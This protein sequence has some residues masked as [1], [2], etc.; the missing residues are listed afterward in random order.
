MKNHMKKLTALLA[1]LPTL[2]FGQAEFTNLT[3]S[4]V[5]TGIQFNASVQSTNDNISVY[6]D[7]SRWVVTRAIATGTN[8]QKVIS[9]TFVD[10]DLIDSLIAMGATGAQASN[11]VSKLPA[12]LKKTARRL[13]TAQLR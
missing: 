2:A 3:Q 11:I 5:W 6:Y 4:T 9:I 10:Q 13:G 1:I 8:I 12:A 7:E